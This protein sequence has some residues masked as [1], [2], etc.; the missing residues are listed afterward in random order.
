MLTQRGNCGI[1][2]W[3]QLTSTEWPRHTFFAEACGKCRLHPQTP[4]P[5]LTTPTHWP[6]PTTDYTVMFSFSYWLRKHTPCLPVGITVW[7]WIILIWNYESPVEFRFNLT[8]SRRTTQA[9][10]TPNPRVLNSNLKQLI[11]SFAAFED[12]AFA[13]PMPATAIYYRYVLAST[14]GMFWSLLLLCSG[15]YYGFSSLY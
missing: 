6:P 7:D 13:A 15:L 4:T 14:T 5:S 12:D 9:A 10:A 11:Y 3:F 1:D 2:T 8:P